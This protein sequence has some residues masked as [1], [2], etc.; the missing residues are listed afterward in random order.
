PLGAVGLADL[1]FAG[2]LDAVVGLYDHV[3]LERDI[4]A[5]VTVQSVRVVS[6]ALTGI[7]DAADV[8]DRVPADF[9]VHSLVV[10]DRTNAL[11]SN[12]VDPDVV[13][14]VNEVIGDFK[15]GHVSIHVHGFA[16]PGPQV[17][18]LVATDDQLRDGSLRRTV[19]GDAESITVRFRLSRDVVH[20]IVQ[21]LNSRARSCDP[22]AGWSVVFVVGRVMADFKSV[23]DD[24]TLI[25]DID[26]TLCLVPARWWVR[27]AAAHPGPVDHR[28]LSGIAFEGD[29]GRGRSRRRKIDR[30]VVNSS[31]YVYRSAC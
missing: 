19:N 29:R 25:H 18:D 26:E 12:R 9:P 30:L 16:A 24:V 6:I 7:R 4:G 23:D 28:G 14:V 13:I 2:G 22:D 11:V 31:E 27:C 5:P 1:I 15:V 21:N 20:P 10:A 3:P 17:V 8:V